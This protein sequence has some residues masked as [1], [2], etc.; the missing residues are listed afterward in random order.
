MGE[1]VAPNTDEAG[2]KLLFVLSPGDLVYVPDEGEHVD[3]IQDIG[4]IYKM[5]SASGRQCFFVP[6]RVALPINSPLELGANNKAE[7][8]WD[9]VMIKNVCL[10]LQV[11]RLGIVTKIYQ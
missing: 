5:V 7:K 4:R 10:K 1:T 11:N 6:F 3:E 8:T 2:H 9:E